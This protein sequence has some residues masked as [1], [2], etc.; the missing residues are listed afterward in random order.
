MR[1]SLYIFKTIFIVRNVSPFTLPIETLFSVPVPCVNGGFED[2]AYNFV[3]MSDVSSADD[4]VAESCEWSK[5][6]I[7][8]IRNLRVK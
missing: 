4:L 2:D 5:I 6:A 1:C 8:V 3:E 7:L